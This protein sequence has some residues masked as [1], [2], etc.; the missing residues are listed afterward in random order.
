MSRGKYQIVNFT[1]LKLSEAY[2][3]SLITSGFYKYQN[4]SI[5]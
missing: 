2:E 1:K 5:D 4:F 3:V